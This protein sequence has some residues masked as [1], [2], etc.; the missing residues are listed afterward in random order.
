MYAKYGS[1]SISRNI[2]KLRKPSRLEGPTGGLYPEIRVEESVFS[3]YEMCL[4]K[5]ARENG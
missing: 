2:Q 1:N 4:H 5:E 3:M